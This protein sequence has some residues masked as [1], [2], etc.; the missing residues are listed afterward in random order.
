MDITNILQRRALTLIEL[1]VVLVVLTI[2]ATIAIRATDSVFSQSR[3]EAT[4]RT[5]RQ[6]DLAIVGDRDLRQSDGTPIVTGFLADVGRLPRSVPTDIPGQNLRELWEQALWTD[7]PY[8]V[9]SPEQHPSIRIASGW[10]GPY[11]SP[12]LGSS[13]I[14]DGWGRP[15]IMIESDPQDEDGFDLRVLSAGADGNP[16]T[17]SQGDT[18]D[19]YNFN[20]FSDYAAGLPVAVSVSRRTED[21]L[22]YFGQ[23]PDFLAAN[24]RLTI[25]LF[26]PD[27]LQPNG[28]RILVRTF[29]ESV[30]AG[31]TGI[32]FEDVPPGYRAFRAYLHP[33]TTPVPS[34]PTNPETSPIKFVTRYVLIPPT[35][36][37]TVELIFPPNEDD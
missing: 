23:D 25:M 11:L 4:V 27:A 10:R 12:G 8:R 14:L 2:L 9:R 21:G 33:D 36:I 6:L 28:I 26:L 16:N 35:G 1:L 22:K 18:T 17:A 30:P 34:E 32:L 3:Y 24:Q 7:F 5:L 37:T 13:S 31:F 29:E 20:L 15:F 19:P